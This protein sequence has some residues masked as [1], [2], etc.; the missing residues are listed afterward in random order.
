MTDLDFLEPGKKQ[1]A[2][3]KFLERAKKEAEAKGRADALLVDVEKARRAAKTKHGKG[4][5]T[6]MRAGKRISR[7]KQAKRLAKK[8][9]ARARLKGAL[10]PERKQSYH[11]RRTLALPGWKVMAARMKPGKW[12]EFAQLVAL[13]PEYS[14]NSVKAWAFQMMPRKGVIDRVEHPSPDRA[15]EGGWFRTGP[16]YLYRINSAA[17]SAAQEWRK[18]LGMV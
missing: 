10:T 9:E 5:K 4:S 11:L 7:T 18:A 15:A 12:Y 1:P 6:R 8:I 17:G 13:M 14:R 16:S 3:L 2:G